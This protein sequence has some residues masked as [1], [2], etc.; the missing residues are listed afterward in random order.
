MIGVYDVYVCVC[1][2]DSNRYDEITP[3][4]RPPKSTQEISL[5]RTVKVV[6]RPQVVCK[7]CSNV[8][9]EQEYVLIFD[10]VLCA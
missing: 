4:I 8:G 3:K 7:L 9:C 10:N 1:V 6:L 2:Y 5:V